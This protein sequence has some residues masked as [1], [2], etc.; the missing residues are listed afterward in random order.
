MK[1]CNLSFDQACKE[2]KLQLA[3]LG[4]L[5]ELQDLQSEGETLPCNMILRKEFKVNQK[6]LLFHYR[7]KLIVSKLHSKWDEP[8][9]ITNVFSY[10]TIEI[11][12]EATN[13]IFKVNEH[14]VK[15]FHKSL[16]MVESD[17]ED[18]SL[19][20]PTLCKYLYIERVLIPLPFCVVKS[21]TKIYNFPFTSVT[22]FELFQGQKSSSSYDLSTLLFNSHYDVYVLCKPYLTFFTI[23]SLHK[24][25]ASAYTL[26]GLSLYI[27]AQFWDFVVRHFWRP[28]TLGLRGILDHKFRLYSL[29]YDDFHGWLGSFINSRF[30]DY[31]LQDCVLERFDIAQQN[32]HK[33]HPIASNINKHR[34]PQ[35]K[36]PK[37]PLGSFFLFLQ[38][39][40]R[41]SSP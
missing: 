27:L 13:K 15:P 3:L 16:T 21:N 39:L 38:H 31:A 7:L 2:R 8:F 36:N 25:L 19:V 1:K 11:K 5:C 40:F 41:G 14:Q 6:V 24:V 23:K 28:L 35:I 34:G 22:Q 29:F 12:N 18:L 37:P 32:I 26:L 9:V 33:K 4:G 10:G 20:K 30:Y 17:V